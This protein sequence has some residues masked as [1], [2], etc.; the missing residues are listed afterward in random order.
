MPDFQGG[1]EM[2]SLRR[3]RA[4]GLFVSL[5]T[6]FSVWLIASVALAE[7]FCVS[8]ETELQAAL[9]E[10]A[11]NNQDDFIKIRQGT[12]YGSFTYNSTEAYSLTSKG[13][14]Y[15]P[16][17]KK[18]VV[19]PANTVLDGQNNGSV[20][21][22]SAPNVNTSITISGLTLRNGNP[23]YMDGGGLYVNAVNSGLNLNETVIRNSYSNGDGG[24][25][26]ISA[27]SV[28][29]TNNQIT[30]NQTGISDETSGGGVYLEA[31]NAIV[32][33]NV[34]SYNHS[35]YRGGGV[36]IQ[37]INTD[38]FDNV[39][40]NNSSNGGGGISIMFGSKVTLVNN[41]INQ[42]HGKQY[43]GG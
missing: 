4:Y 7:T 16:R 8:D 21:S 31:S 39:V 29:L 2:R 40:S 14:Y 24:G 26:Y 22:L 20:L 6:G 27:N 41:N 36:Y 25:A 37:S 18:R 15:H 19:D 43:G 12:Y 28:N 11:I 3:K 30:N 32:S 38:F 10:A 42:N 35:K 9:D 1:A 34:F 17:C 5:V 23:Y 33:N 13:G